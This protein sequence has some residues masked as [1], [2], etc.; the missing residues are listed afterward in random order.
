MLAVSNTSPISNL[1]ATDRLLLLKSQ[2]STVSTPDAV[3]NELA[4]HPDPVAREA[5]QNAIREGWLRIEPVQD[6]PV[7]TSLRRGRGYC[8]RHG[9]QAD[10]VLI[11][12]QEGRQLASKAGLAVTGVLGVLLRAR[13]KGDIAAIKAEIDLLRSKARFFVSPLLEAKVLVAAGE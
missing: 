6:S 3:A 12:E 8:A 10:I 1:A 13:R 7:A 4:T 11:D 5:I 9:P 2:F